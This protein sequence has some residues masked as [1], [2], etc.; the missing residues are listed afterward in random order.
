MKKKVKDM[1][2]IQKI[3]ARRSDYSRRKAEELIV[4]R[5]V[6][7]NGKIV[8][9]LGTLASGSD[10]I[11][12]DGNVIYQPEKIYYLVNKP[13]KVISSTSDEH[14]RAII[15]DLVDASEKVYPVGRLDY[16]TTG[17]ILLTN[18]GELANKLMHPKYEVKKIYSVKVEGDI[19]YDEI[20][21]LRS[22]IEIDG[23]KTSH[24]EVTKIS[25][26]KKTNQSTVEVQIHEGRNQQ[27]RKMF[28]SV[29]YK[30]K[31]LNRIQY[32]FFKIEEEKI[33]RGKARR[34]KI[35]EVQKLYNL[36]GDQ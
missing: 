21:K 27:V 23:Y 4:E 31:T 36:V 3:I 28:L 33:G 20:K 17:L 1:E 12:I 7:L 16:Y 9:E 8:Q 24:A 30:V 5:R 13:I 10:E 14:E 19:K 32:A 15:T 22:G 34:L 35:K 18:D 11:L 25:Y 29:G 2:R 26:N 6:T